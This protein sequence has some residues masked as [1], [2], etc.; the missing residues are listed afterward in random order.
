MP[1][2]AVCASVTSLPLTA[3]EDLASEL[4]PEQG[5]KDDRPLLSEPSRIPPGC[6]TSRHL[7]DLPTPEMYFR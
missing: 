6:K 3:G 7:S 2:P 4:E 5:G 1:N